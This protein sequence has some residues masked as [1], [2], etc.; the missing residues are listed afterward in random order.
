M[1]RRGKEQYCRPDLTA[2]LAQLS[3]DKVKRVRWLT[4]VQDS[5][6]LELLIVDML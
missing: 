5:T 2:V 4:I 1:F 3:A 6:I